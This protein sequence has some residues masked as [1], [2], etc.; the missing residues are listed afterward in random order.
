MRFALLFVAACAT[1]TPSAPEVAW[2]TYGADVTM[3]EVTPVATVLDT[4]DQFVGKTVLVEGQVADVCQ[5]A[6]CW[7]VVS[8]GKRTMR[9]T[10]KDHAFSVAK[11]GTGATCRVEGQVVAKAVDP[12]T[13]AHFKGESARPDVAPE[14]ERTGAAMTYELV[15]SGVQLKR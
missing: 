7:M 10:M 14:A 8:D 2:S 4:P 15:A 11:D 13:V 5:K 1:S 3:S 12:K 9:M 6:G